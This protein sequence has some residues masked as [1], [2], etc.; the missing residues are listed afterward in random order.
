ML[1]NSRSG[2][3]YQHEASSQSSVT[4]RWVMDG[5]ERRRQRRLCIIISN[6]NGTHILH[7][8]WKPLK[9]SYNV[10][11]EANKH[12]M[13]LSSWEQESCLQRDAGT[14]ARCSAAFIHF[15]FA[16]KLFI[17]INVLSD[18]HPGL[19]SPWNRVFVCL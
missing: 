13:R 16:W 5:A 4:I 15:F 6:I 18:Y 11:V 7:I 2:A 9:K 17:S 8:I 14:E 12:T 3:K 1:L 10:H 19:L